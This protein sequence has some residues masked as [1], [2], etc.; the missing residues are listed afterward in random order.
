MLGI[1]SPAPRIGSPVL[2]IS[3][4]T[5]ALSTSTHLHRRNAVQAGHGNSDKPLHPPRFAQPF[6]PGVTI[7]LGFCLPDCCHRSLPGSS[8]SLHTSLLC[9][10]NVCSPPR[11]SLSTAAVPS[12]GQGVERQPLGKQRW[13]TVVYSRRN[14]LS[15]VTFHRPPQSSPQAPTG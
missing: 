14:L 5:S 12:S 2:R 1:L 11:F 13:Y 8:R 4:V 6:L 9:C 7:L 15:S 3:Y 10:C